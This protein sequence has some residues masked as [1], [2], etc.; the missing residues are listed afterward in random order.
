MPHAHTHNRNLF[1][2]FYLFSLCFCVLLC[3]DLLTTRLDSKLYSNV[4]KNTLEHYAAVDWVDMVGRHL[5]WLWLIALATTVC[6]HNHHSYRYVSQA[7]VIARYAKTENTFDLLSRLRTFQTDQAKCP[8]VWKRRYH[9]VLSLNSY[10]HISA[11]NVFA[12]LHSS[13]V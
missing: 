2:T 3:S 6:W 4:Y 12:H 10:I 7:M 11:K 9:I 5:M 13:I 1:R 8:C